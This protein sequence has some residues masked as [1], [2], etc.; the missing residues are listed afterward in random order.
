MYRKNEENITYVDGMNMQQKKKKP[1]FSQVFVVHFNIIKLIKD[2][3]MSRST[4]EGNANVNLSMMPFSRCRSISKLKTAQIPI[5]TEVDVCS[6][7]NG[8]YVVG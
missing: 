2:M 7:T 3:G 4:E 1:I 5:L 6:F 8:M